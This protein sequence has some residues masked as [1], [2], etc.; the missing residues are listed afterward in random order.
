[1]TSCFVNGARNGV[2]WGMD[3]ITIERVYDID[4]VMSVLGRDDIW[5]HISPKG[6]MPS[7]FNP[8]MTEDFYYLAAMAPSL[9]GI[10]IYHPTADRE[11]MTHHQ[12]LPEH[13][14]SRSIDYSMASVDW[15]FRNTDTDRLICEIPEGYEN[16][17]AHA[18]KGGFTKYCKVGDKVRLELE[19][20]KWASQAY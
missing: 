14:G 8:P 17:I 15:I 5:P 6:M 16:V 3:S 10:F 18:E 1:M 9:V 13:R 2:Q 11:M 7:D 4:V 19:R 20:D 12:V